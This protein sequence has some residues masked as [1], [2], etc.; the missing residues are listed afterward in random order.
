MTDRKTELLVACMQLLE[1]QDN[2]FIVLDLLT[3]TVRY[4][5]ADC[6]GYCLLEDIKAELNLDQTN[7]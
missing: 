2:S 5:G 7:I 3:E 6:D 4:D 1:K